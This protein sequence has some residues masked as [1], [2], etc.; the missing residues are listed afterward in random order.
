MIKKL[1]AIFLMLTV[2]LS[3]FA[4]CK[5]E[6][7]PAQPEPAT[8]SDNSASAQP[9]Q[10][11]EPVTIHLAG[12]KGPTS[13]G[14]VKLMEDNETGTTENN[15]EFTVAG[16]ADEIT[17]SL[18][19]GKLDMAA[20]P[21]NLASVLYNKTEGDI[22]ILAVN[23]LGVLYIVGKGTEI[24][25]FADLAGKTIYATGQGSTPE[26]NLRYLLSQN[27]LDPDKDVTIEF[28]SEPAEIVNILSSSEE[29]I[30]ML[31]QPYVIAASAQVE[32]LE[33]KLS[34]SDEWDSLENGS[35][36]VTG[37]LAVRR[38]FVE[39]NPDVVEKFLK[40]YAASVD[41]VN[42]NVDDAAEL[43]EKYDLFKAAVAK[44]AILL[45][46]VVYIAGKDMTE[47]VEK[48]LQVLFEEN[49]QA[50]GGK[51]PDSDFYYEG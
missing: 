22:Q 6:A 42:S 32:G 1:F 33:V 45:C 8:D 4:G 27:G 43:V 38:Q 14:L 39:E 36:M 2:I 26:Y 15:Y 40:D 47:P 30:A 44:K 49:P 21:V 7:V 28:K 29:G 13:I 5:K 11:T 46:N 12:L 17:P 3:L 24:N 48:Y 37:V 20:L 25:G 19:Q 51:L 9:E 10:E 18:I 41:Y 35:M 31:P 23:T 34:L 50:V 16:S